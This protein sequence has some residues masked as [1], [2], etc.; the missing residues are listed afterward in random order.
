MSDTTDCEIR[1]TWFVQQDVN[2]WTSLAYL[3]TGIVLV[4][5]IVGRRLPRAALGLALALAV[6]GV[7]SW[8]YHGSQGEGAQ[9]L[10]DVPLIGALG[11]VAGWHVGRLLSATDLGSLVGLAI[12]VA[13]ASV[14]WVVEPGATNVTAAVAVVVIVAASLLAR[15]RHFP[16]VWTVPVIVLGAIAAATWLLG[17]PNSPLCD[18]ESWLQPHGFWH[19][20]TAVVALAWADSAYAAVRPD[21]PPRMFRR[22]T[23]RTIGLVARGLVL[24]FHRSVDVAFRERFPTDR[25]VLVVA[26]HGNGFVDPV[27]VAGV[28]GRLPRFLAK[29]ALWKVIIARPFLGLAGVLPVYRSG[30]GDRPTDNESVFAACHAELAHGA[31]VAIFPE[32]TTGDRAGLDR[33]KSGAARI[34]LGALP[35]SP[36]LAI[37]PIGIAYESKVETR[38][39]VAVMFGEPID[40]DDFAGSGLLGD[41]EPHRG[42]ARALTDRITTSLQEVSPDFADNDEREILRAAARVERSRGRRAP[43]FASTEV[44]ARRLA[45]ADTDARRIVVDTYRRFATRLQLI[46]ITDEQLRPVRVSLVRLVLSAVALFLAGSLVVAFTLI[47]LPAVAV[48]TIGTASVHSTATKGTV[49]ILL[50]LVTMLATWTIAGIWL[51]DGWGAVGYA[52]AIA[53]GGA[54]ALAVW[55]PLWHQGVILLGWVRV[56]DRVG[57]LPP[58]RDARSDV[59]TAVRANAGGLDDRLG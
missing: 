58:V 11:F 15:R 59:V 53:V 33:V 6:E 45:R 7:G 35:T 28:L 41:G 56:R 20:L 54:I 19:V 52:V 50:G 8:L 42:D 30:D 2:A 57:L 39:R 51:G 44:V 38:S 10:H 49:R 47:H 29:A 40:V 48:V 14:L 4:I 23:D 55:P 31:T 32:G 26:N 5:E 16:G 24:G 22:F 36:N 21:R 17:Q 27:V 9:F 3:A 34:A 1:D 18:D 37:V 13:T 43:S 46:G 12:G 25:P